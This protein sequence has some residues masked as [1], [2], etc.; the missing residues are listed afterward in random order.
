[1]MNL[2]AIKK[3]ALENEF[4]DLET[5]AQKVQ[6]LKNSGISFLACIAFVQFNQRISLAE[7]RKLTLELAVYSDIEK[8]KIDDMNRLMYSEFE[9]E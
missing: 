4:L 3:E 6:E 1:M 7:A 8:K 9:E 5:L 2:E